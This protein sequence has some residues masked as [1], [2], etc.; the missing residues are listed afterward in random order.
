MLSAAHSRT[1]FGVKN[2]AVG[3]P[4][5]L[6][7]ETAHRTSTAQVNGR[8]EGHR[9]RS[10]G[11]DGGSAALCCV[12]SATAEMKGCEVFP[13]RAPVIHVGRS[14]LVPLVAGA[15][16]RPERAHRAPRERQT[17]TRRPRRPAPPLLLRQRSP[18]RLRLPPV[19]VRPR[20]QNHH[21]RHEPLLLPLDPR[22]LL[23]VLGQ[24]VRQ[25]LPLL[26]RFRERLLELADLVLM[27]GYE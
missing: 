8:I 26:R 11:R 16:W 4:A 17:R 3:G 13:S 9:A 1:I 2:A 18:R 6:W 10:T 24:G 27:I 20:L 19:L 12:G 21:L 5:Q 25:P 23:R 14:S 7:A 22:H 15:H